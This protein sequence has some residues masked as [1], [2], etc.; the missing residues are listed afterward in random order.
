MCIFFC[1]FLFVYIVDM[2]CLCFLNFLFFYGFLIM[3]Y[4][5][6]IEYCYIIYINKLK[7]YVVISKWNSL[8]VLVLLNKC[9]RCFIIVYLV[10]V[11][12]LNGKIR[13]LVWIFG[14]CIMG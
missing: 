5:W 7:V 3:F 8:S 9:L 14:F 12:V 6:V 4:I 1:D 13:S 10:E 2:I 11:V